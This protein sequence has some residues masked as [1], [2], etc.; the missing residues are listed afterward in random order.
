MC[1]QKTVAIRKNTLKGE[2]VSDQKTCICL[3]AEQEQSDE[4][5]SY[6]TSQQYLAI[7]KN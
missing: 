5:N 3:L 4:A 1:H 2:R 6:K 7:A